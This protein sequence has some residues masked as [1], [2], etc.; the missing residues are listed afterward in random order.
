[1]GNFSIAP[2]LSEKGFTLTALPNL[3]TKVLQLAPANIISACDSSA[4]VL[5]YS[6]SCIDDWPTFLLEIDS[7]CLPDINLLTADMYLVCRLIEADMH[8]AVLSI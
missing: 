4:L 8:R 5:V 7:N 2:R 6:T 3:M 1:M